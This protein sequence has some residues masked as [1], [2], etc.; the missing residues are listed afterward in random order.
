MFKSMLIKRGNELINE[1]AE[2]KSFLRIF[3]KAL[4]LEGIISYMSS[5]VQ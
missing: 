3:T 2:E 4:E 1:I 5:N